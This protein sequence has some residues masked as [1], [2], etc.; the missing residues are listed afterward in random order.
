[1]NASNFMLITGLLC[2]LIAG[3]EASAAIEPIISPIIL[4]TWASH[5]SDP[6]ISIDAVEVLEV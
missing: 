6:F 3:D 5:V 1:M 2:I 4:N